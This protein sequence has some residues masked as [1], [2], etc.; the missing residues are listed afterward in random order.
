[1]ESRMIVV[2]DNIANGGEKIHMLSKAICKG[3]HQ[4][5]WQTVLESTHC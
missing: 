3:N 5:L 1:M 2:D 4:V